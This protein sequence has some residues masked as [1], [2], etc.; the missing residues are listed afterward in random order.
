M[1]IKDDIELVYIDGYKKHC[2]S[3]LISLTIDYKKQ[4]LIIGIK[5]NM[6]YL[7]DYI[8]L[9]EKELIT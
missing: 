4:I 7:I 8:L 2:Y 5:V 6:Q 1:Y 3:I 9:K